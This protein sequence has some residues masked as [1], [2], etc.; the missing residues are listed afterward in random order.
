MITLTEIR[1]YLKLSDTDT[2]HDTFLTSL[3]DMVATDIE[4]RCGRSLRFGQY[5]TTIFNA[6]SHNQIY[7]PVTPVH[8][9]TAVRYFDGDQYTNLFDDDVSGHIRV[10]SDIGLVKFNDG[11]SIRNLDL[12]IVHESGYKFFNA[13]GTVD[14]THGTVDVV[15]TG[16]AFTTEIEV[17]DRVVIAG[18]TRTVTAIADNTHLT[19]N[20]SLSDTVSDGSITVNTF[21]SDLR[22]VA[23]KITAYNY[24]QSPHAENFLHRSSG[25]FN[26]NSGTGD[27]YKD[28]N[29]S[30]T[31]NKYK[32]L[33]V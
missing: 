13:T 18:Q 29:V 2:V 20:E 4:T 17:D 15:G 22:D 5:I 11:T 33:N 28:L 7:L 16:T 12:E 3:I 21:P 1:D 27:T 31:I 32:Y 9:V 30:N 10:M 14:V 6:N 19:I 26:L 25:N 8:S 24:L 23:L